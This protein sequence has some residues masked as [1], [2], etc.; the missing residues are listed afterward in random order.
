MLVIKITQLKKIPKKIALQIKKINLKQTH[1]LSISKTF[2]LKKKI[3]API[4]E[5]NSQS[6]EAFLTT[7]PNSFKMSTK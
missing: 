3:F 6:K 1:F 7:K 2:N 4:K 5:L